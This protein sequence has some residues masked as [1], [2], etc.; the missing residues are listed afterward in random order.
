MESSICPNCGNP[1]RV[2]VKFCTHCGS[3]LAAPAPAPAKV[4]GLPQSGYRPPAAAPAPAAGGISVGTVN[5]TN[6]IVG[7]DANMTVSYGP[8]YDL[9]GDFRGALLSIE[10]TLRDTQQAIGALPAAGDD[11]RAG[12][13]RLIVR[14]DRALLATP[15][16]REAEATEVAD[17]AKELIEKAGGPKPRPA[18]IRGHGDALREAAAA[19]ADAVPDAPDIAGQLA[20]A[21][22]PGDGLTA[23]A[24]PLLRSPAPRPPIFPLPTPH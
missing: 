6:V 9:S 14:L 7:N 13:R 4:A 2:G 16:G 21:L 11:V 24:P 18:V 5:A 17:L 15:P 1:N 8:R 3:T 20:A 12:L 22:R 23:P 10:S 19:L